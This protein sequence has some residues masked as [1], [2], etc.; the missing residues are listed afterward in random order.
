MNV[1]QV[2]EKMQFVRVSLDQ[3]LEQVVGVLKLPERLL[4]L[5][6]GKEQTAQL[7]MNVGQPAPVIRLFGVSPDQVLLQRAGL[8]IL[9]GR[10]LALPAS[11]K[12]TGQ[13]DVGANQFVLIGGNARLC[14]DEVDLDG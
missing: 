3:G 1:R 10:L 8:Q 6:L 13:V 11:G 12:K 4:V 2:L 14:L 5:A 7:E 9:L